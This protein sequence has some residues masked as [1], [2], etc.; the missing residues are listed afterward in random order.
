MTALAPDVT[1][2]P[3]PR[4]IFFCAGEASGDLHGGNLL[5]AM[6]QASPGITY[7]GIGGE[8]MEA[9]GMELIEHSR[10]MAV[11]GLTEIFKHLP[12][13][14]DV[15]NRCMSVLRENRPD[16]LVLIDYPE[17]NFILGKAAHK[18]GI[19]IFYY[20]SPQIWAWRRG[21][22]KSMRQFVAKVFPLFPFEEAFYTE[23]GVPVEFVGNP[24]VDE[25]RSRLTPDAFRKEQAIDD[26]A[27]YVT[28]MPGSRRSEIGRLF[29][30]MLDAAEILLQERDDLRFLVPVPGDLEDTLRVVQDQLA[31]RKL[32]AQAFLRNAA[33]ALSVS[34]AAAV[35]S[36]TSTMEAAIVGT[37]MVVAYRMSDFSMFAA[38]LVI[39]VKHIAMVNLLA[40]ERLVPELLQELVTPENM[41]TELRRMLSSPAERSRIQDGYTRVINALRGED[42]SE[43]A[44][45]AILRSFA[46]LPQELKPAHL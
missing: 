45:E 10:N 8:R 15:F 23:G 28:L 14:R 38:R 1:T 16:L 39:D 31:A 35:K 40:G 43:R 22:V 4:R 24:M 36:G 20:I 44:A 21:R 29:G 25:V 17:F 33:N 41:A 13:F 9:E 32:P 2:P 37:P 7:V 46:H 5:R 18:L 6:S 19:P 12:F 42:A 3:V 30:T 27:T 11:V 34:A 26:G